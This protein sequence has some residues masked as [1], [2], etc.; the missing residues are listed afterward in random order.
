MSL[1]HVGAVAAALLLMTPCLASAQ[2]GAAERQA[3]TVRIYNNFGVKADD[4]SVAVRQAETIL[5]N[6]RIDI[7]W[8]N[9]WFRDHAPTDAPAG[10]LQAPAGNDLVLRLQ[11]GTRPEQTRRVSMGFSLVS[12]GPANA[13]HYLEGTSPAF[14]STVY[15]DVV[16]SV[17]RSTTLEPRVLLGLAIAHEL[18]HLL[19]NTNRHAETGLMRALWSRA[20]LNRHVASDWRFLDEEAVTMRGAIAT[21]AS[22]NGN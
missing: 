21:R 22:G 3:I 10:C 1:K 5:G 2:M 11:G 7:T 13:G 18:G 15:V 20:E 6:A 4:L 19:L 16:W 12:E 9:C 8:V 17:S 14:L